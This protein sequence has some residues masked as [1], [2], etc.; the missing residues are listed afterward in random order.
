MSFVLVSADCSCCKP[1]ERAQIYPLLKNDGWIKMSE[2]SS[3]S[4]S[5]WLGAL[6][7]DVTNEDAM[8]QAK[9]KF[10]SCFNPNCKP[11]IVF[12][13]STRECNVQTVA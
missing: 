4:T 9:N 3:D 2:D 1:E 6:A 11:S 12:H 10:Y 7:R 8:D 13:W 5:V